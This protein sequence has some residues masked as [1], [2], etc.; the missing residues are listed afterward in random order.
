MRQKNTIRRL[1]KDTEHTTMNT[2]TTINNKTCSCKAANTHESRMNKERSMK[3][4]LYYRYKKKFLRFCSVYS[5]Q[6]KRKA[7]NHKQKHNK[8]Q[9]LNCCSYF[10]T[11]FYF[12]C[13]YYLPFCDNF[14]HCMAFCFCCVST[15]LYSYLCHNCNPFYY[16]H[17]ILSKR[18]IPC[19][20]QHR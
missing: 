8:R 7:K 17:F 5:F 11:L 6:F 13:C 3:V 19:I 15:C 12:N 4:E 1:S 18:C 2:Q 16:E 20:A 14:L 9:A 10:P